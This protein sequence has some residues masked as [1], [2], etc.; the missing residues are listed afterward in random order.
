[1]SL[2]DITQWPLSSS[3]IVNNFV[4]CILTAPGYNNSSV[5]NFSSPLNNEHLVKKSSDSLEVSFHR[6]DIG[7][8]KVNGAVN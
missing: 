8:W 6:I 1:M 2:P 3:N 7:T 5:L 4:F